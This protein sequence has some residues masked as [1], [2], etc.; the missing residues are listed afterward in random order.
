MTSID[1]DTWKNYQDYPVGLGYDEKEDYDFEIK[2]AVATSAGVVAFALLIIAL[3][4]RS[5]IKR[6]LSTWLRNFVNFFSTPILRLTNFR[7]RDRVANISMACHPPSTPSPLE[8]ESMYPNSSES[9]SFSIPG[10][11]PT[12]RPLMIENNHDSLSR[13]RM[14]SMLINEM[15]NR[16][17]PQLE[18]ADESTLVVSSPD[19]QNRYSTPLPVNLTH[20]IH[21][22]SSTESLDPIGLLETPANSPSLRRITIDNESEG[23]VV[24]IAD[25]PIIRQQPHRVTR[26]R[27]PIYRDE[28]SDEEN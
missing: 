2:I 20:T 11:Y 15:F 24:A 10:L 14:V 18:M 28:P 6:K 5:A 17:L 9:G 25:F 21:Q 22:R 23:S 1:E 3:R 13:D 27:V 19:D 12:N 7:Q 26:N 4:Y 16:P 8:S